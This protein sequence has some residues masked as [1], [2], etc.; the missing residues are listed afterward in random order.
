ME[1]TTKLFKKTPIIFKGK[2]F[3][4]KIKTSPLP[5]SNILF[6]GDDILFKLSSCIPAEKQKKYIEQK[7][8]SWLKS[9]ARSSFLLIANNICKNYNLNYSQIRIKDTKSR[10]GSCSSKKNLN[11]NWR[12]IMAPQNVINYIVVHETAHLT[13]LNHSQNFWKIVSERCPNY[14]QHEFWLKN[15]GATLLNWEPIII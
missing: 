4:V 3:K 8:F 2:Q 1:N 5:F 6:N 11:F 13:E 10:W 7:I 12:L 15:N 9:Q 14:K